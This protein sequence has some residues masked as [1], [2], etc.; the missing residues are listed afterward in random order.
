MALDKGENLLFF[1][2]RVQL[3]TLKIDNKIIEITPVIEVSDVQ[4]K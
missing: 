2:K 1:A 4:M 3:M